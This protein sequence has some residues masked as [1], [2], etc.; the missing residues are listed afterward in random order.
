MR[1]NTKHIC[2]SCGRKG[3]DCADYTLRFIGE[4]VHS[5]I[6]WKPCEYS[7]QLPE[8]GSGADD[9]VSGIQRTV[10][11]REHDAVTGWL[12]QNGAMINER[13]KDGYDLQLVSQD[14]GNTSVYILSFGEKVIGG[15]KI[16]NTWLPGTVSMACKYV[17]LSEEE[18]KGSVP[19]DAA[20]TWCHACEVCVPDC[21][22]EE[23]SNNDM[24]APQ[25][26]DPVKLANTFRNAEEQHKTELAGITESIKKVEEWERKRYQADK[27]VTLPHGMKCI[28]GSSGRMPSGAEA[29]PYMSR[30]F[31]VPEAATVFDHIALLN[32]LMAENP[33]MEVKFLLGANAWTEGAE[34]SVCAIKKVEIRP[35]LVV[36]ED[37]EV[38]VIVHNRALVEHYLEIGDPKAESRDI[39]SGRLKKIIAVFLG[40]DIEAR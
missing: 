38:T 11:N 34:Y 24:G 6:H 37:D 13:L 32:R 1:A 9:P 3:V 5:C 39:K 10:A 30:R 17:P 18:A 36:A 26:I 4:T 31:I 28:T 19:E 23:T 35:Y 27:P 21:P 15:L 29:A 12:T 40:S 8:E 2:D 20:G 7:V 14:R 25:D 16:V 22:E 33:G